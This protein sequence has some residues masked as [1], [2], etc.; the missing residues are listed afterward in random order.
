MPQSPT[1]TTPPA[2]CCCQ[3]ACARP[4]AGPSSSNRLARRPRGAASSGRTSASISPSRLRAPP[5]PLR[6]RSRSVGSRRA[7]PPVRPGDRCAS[8]S[9]VPVSDGS[10]E[11]H[12]S[13]VCQSAAVSV[14]RMLTACRSPSPPSSPDDRRAGAYTHG[15]ALAL[16]MAVGTVARWPTVL[17]LVSRSAEAEALTGGR[18]P[19]PRS[20]HSSRSLD[21]IQVLMLACHNTLSA[22]VM[23]T[24]TMRISDRR[25][26]GRWMVHRTSSGDHDCDHGGLVRGRSATWVSSVIRRASPDALGVVTGPSP[27]RADRRPLQP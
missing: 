24:Y 17:G 10:Q 18:L 6:R 21:R 27:R 14:A 22:Y 25:I 3:P 26:Q 5:S 13:P 20:L 15:T 16:A 2:S 9:A 4:G 7:R 19:C 1:T 23:T 8:A 11:A 12:T